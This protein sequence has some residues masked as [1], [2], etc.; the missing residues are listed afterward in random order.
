MIE[1][2]YLMSAQYYWND[3][4]KIQYNLRALIDSKADDDHTHP[5]YPPLEHNHDDKYALIEYN[6]ELNDI[7]SLVD[8]LRELLNQCTD[9]DRKLVEHKHSINDVEHL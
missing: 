9:L 2:L 1:E 8:S 7:E 4:G 5:E 6:H 3:I